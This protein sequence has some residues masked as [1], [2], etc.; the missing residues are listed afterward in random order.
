MIS[1]NTPKRFK[2]NFK[3]LLQDD[4]VSKVA[5]TERQLA[6]LQ[7]V[8]HKSESRL[9][10]VTRTL[11]ELEEKKRYTDDKLNKS[12]S[13]ITQNVSRFFLI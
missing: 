5:Q 7:E 9:R 6:E 2:F 11:S 8:H 4:A 12:V 3:N 13:Q 10:D 1:F